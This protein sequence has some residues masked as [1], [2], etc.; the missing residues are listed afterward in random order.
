MNWDKIIDAAHATNKSDGVSLK[1]KKYTTVAV[2]MDLF[3]R[4]FGAWGIET[5]IV[6][7]SHTKG[8]PVV[9]RAAIK[10]EFG[11]IIATGHAFEIVGQGNV[12]STAALENAETSAIG[13]A[14][15][16]CGLHGGE[17]ASINEIDGADRKAKELDTGGGMKE[18][19]ADGVKDRLPP[20]ATPQ[21]TAQGYAD[22]ITEDMRKAKTAKG[23]TGAWDKRAD[24]IDRIAEK[25][26][27][28]HQNL[29]D[30]YQAIINGY[31]EEA[32]DEKI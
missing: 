28:I 10:D 7:F 6:N 17:F 29:L 4:N 15:A 14:L 25:F 1:G 8:D 30:Q 20:N 31:E 16:A 22:Q 2:R 5:D 24:I 12:N 9:M 3:R 21:Q 26:P 32:D 27:D 19:W 23:T 13:R 18:A 11:R